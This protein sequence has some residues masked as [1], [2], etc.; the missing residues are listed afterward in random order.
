MIKKLKQKLHS[1]C[2][3]ESELLYHKAQSANKN[4]IA[5][6]I[7]F[8]ILSK[9]IAHFVTKWFINSLIKNFIDTNNSKGFDIGLKVSPGIVCGAAF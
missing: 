5:L 3:K 7:I 9:Y 8:F 1:L 4:F 6:F 2:E